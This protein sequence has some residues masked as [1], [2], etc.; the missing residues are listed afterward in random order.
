MKRAA[1]IISRAGCL[2]SLLAPIV[3]LVLYPAAKW[4]FAFALVGI[5]IVVFQILTA[6]DP[7]PSDIADS[8]ER[9]LTGTCAGWDVDD[10]EH[11]NPSNP[12]LKDLWLRTMSVGG[13]PEEWVRLD[14]TKQNEV[15]EIIR[16]LRHMALSG[17][18]QKTE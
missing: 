7:L 16:Q 18:R 9:I 1:K 6:K 2:V 17:T 4:L 3:A 8:A 11:L 12:V 13:L 10:Y 14:E 5:V 15:R